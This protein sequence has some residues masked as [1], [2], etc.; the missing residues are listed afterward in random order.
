MSRG[1][2]CG[3]AIS[4]SGNYS[5]N[6]VQHSC[7]H[8]LGHESNAYNVA[9][10]I[11]HILIHHLIVGANG[12]RLVW[13]SGKTRHYWLSQQGEHRSPLR[14]LQAPTASFCSLS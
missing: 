14:I 2:R 8:A 11:L 9:L 4:Y 6:P 3:V 13:M 7:S 10:G 1:G 12:V 5:V